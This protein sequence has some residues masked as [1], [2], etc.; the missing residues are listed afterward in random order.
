MKKKS[1]CLMICFLLFF[2]SHL[3]AQKNVKFEIRHWLGIVPF[4]FEVNSQN[5][6]G[7]DFNV[8]RLEY[9]LSEIAVTHDTGKV[10][11]VVD[12]WLLVDPGQPTLVDLGTMDIDQV[13][14][15]SFHVGVDSAHNHLDPAQ[16]TV[17]HPLG[18][19]SPSM[20]WGWAAGYR[21]I[22]IEGN[23]GLNLRS[24]YQLHGLGDRNYIKTEIASPMVTSTP[25]EIIISLDADYAKVLQWVDISLPVL[26]HGESGAAQ[27]ALGNMRDYVFTPADPSTALEDDGFDFSLRIFPNP[28]NG[29]QIKLILPER[30]HLGYRVTVSDVYGRQLLERKITSRNRGLTFSLKKAGIYMVS[31]IHNEEI[32]VSKKLVVNP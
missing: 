4:G 10:T 12:Y 9:Y 20:H 22:A 13:E 11:K 27:R 32:L 21:F 28:S 1:T 24:E 7:I 26:I 19:K 3:S 14:S 25:E 29:E 17:A 8:S 30:T 16:Y 15:I 5:N 2:G 23:S 31:V 18:P 6:L